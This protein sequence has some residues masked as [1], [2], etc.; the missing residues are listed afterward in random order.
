MDPWIREAAA[1]IAAR[2]ARE[3]EALVAVSSPSGDVH[4]ANECASVC[5]ALLPGEATIERVPCSSPGHAQDLVA[6]LH[7]TGTGKALLVGHVDTVVAHEEHRP[8]ERVGEQLLGSGSVDMKG[9]DVL[10]IGALRAFAKRPELYEQLALLLVC[11]EE[12]RTADFGHVAR[13]TGFDACLCFE[14]GELKGADEGVVVKRKAAGTIHITAH[15]R[16]AHSGSAPDRGRNALLALAKAAQIV[17]LEHDPQGV[18]HLTAVPTV[19]RSGDAFNVVPGTGELYCDVRADD[20]GA[21]ERVLEKLPAEIDQVRIEAE[22]IR[23]WPGMHSEAAV[24]PVLDAASSALGRRVAPA[25]R[26]GASDAS[27]F[28]ATIP[29]TIDGLGPRGGKA[30][31]PEEFVLE[32]SLQPR[33]EVA[34]AVIVAALAA[35]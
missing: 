34:L 18:A 31:N 6:R 26:G 25:A 22:L 29:I 28:A 2:A 10:A 32:A 5:T 14:A 12:W 24:A 21:I 19:M 13:F 7:G 16:S 20:L 30:H 11:D 23:R 1:E 33:A 17:A 4:G 27:H 15:G 9:G 8:L 3:L 35:A